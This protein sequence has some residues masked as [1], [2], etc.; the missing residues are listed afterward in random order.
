MLGGWLVRDGGGVDDVVVA[1]GCNGGASV[2]Y[3]R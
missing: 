1:I 3:M 2:D